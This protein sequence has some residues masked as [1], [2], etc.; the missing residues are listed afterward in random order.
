MA[1]KHVSDYQVCLAY[2]LC[3]SGRCRLSYGKGFL[4]PFPEEVL[5]IWTKQPQKVC[6]RAIE[7]A[8]RRGLI[9]YGVSLRSGWLTEAGRAILSA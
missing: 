6:Y 3:S 4:V 9:D 7:R 5:S 8:F 1:R 2:W